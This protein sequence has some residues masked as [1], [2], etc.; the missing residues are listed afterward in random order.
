VWPV[1]VAGQ[2]IDLREVTRRARRASRATRTT[3]S[4]ATCA[5]SDCRTPWT[6]GA[7]QNAR[8]GL[9][10]RPG[11]PAWDPGLCLRAGGA[12][13]ASGLGGVV[14][15]V[16]P[17]PVGGSLQVARIANRRCRPWLPAVAARAAGAV[18]GLGAASVLR[19]LT[20]S[21]VLVAQ[22]AQGQPSRHGVQPEPRGGRA[23]PLRVGRARSRTSRLDLAEAGRRWLGESLLR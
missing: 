7:P 20:G 5:A 12:P 23:V 6:H 19:F 15:D 16:P 18:R 4:S 8:P 10:P 22:P 13:P 9:G 21:C 17:W 1:S 14:H 3:S 2:H 11:T